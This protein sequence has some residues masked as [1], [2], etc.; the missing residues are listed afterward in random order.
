ME[1]N[2][3][4]PKPELWKVRLLEERRELLAR[5]IKLKKAFDNP[6]MKLNNR[7]WEMLRAQFSFMRDYLQALTDRCV[8][9]NWKDAPECPPGHKDSKI[10]CYGYDGSWDGHLTPITAFAAL[11]DRISGKG[12]WKSNPWVFVYEFEL[13]K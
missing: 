4:E 7:E 12:T 9:Y 2:R 13:V 1:G 5:T 8:Y 11:I 10:E 6:E 3:P